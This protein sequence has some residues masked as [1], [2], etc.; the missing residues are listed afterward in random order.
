MRA[1]AVLCSG[2]LMVAFLLVLAPRTAAAQDADATN[3]ATPAPSSAANSGDAATP[4][5][6]A[7]LDSHDSALL[8]Q[9]LMFDPVTLADAAPV[10]S[11]KLPR[12]TTPTGPDVSGDDKEDGSAT[13]AIKQSLPTDWNAKVGVDLAVAAPPPVSYQP[14]RPLPGTAGGSNSGAAWASVDLTNNASIEARLDPGS[15]QGRVGTTLQHSLALGSDFS[16]TLRDNVTLSDAL[17]TTQGASTAPAGLPVMA[18]P[19][20]TT[21]TATEPVWKNKPGV[22]F[23]ILSTGTSLAANLD[24]ASDDLVTHNT[25]SADQKLYGPLH[26]TTSVTD[27]GESTVNK[28]ITAGFKVNW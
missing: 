10:K 23:N 6:A 26:V 14:D 8:G 4:A 5:P 15:D 3:V 12:L 21:S 2:C 13:V 7:P 22:K 25:L 20:S 24:T 16:L 9:A 18:L 28:S 11:L 19:Q 17:G 27:L 1:F